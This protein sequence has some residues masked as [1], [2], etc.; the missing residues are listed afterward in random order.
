LHFSYENHTKISN[1]IPKFTKS[2]P[3]LCPEAI[4]HVKEGA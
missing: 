2:T 3:N 1:K 4:N